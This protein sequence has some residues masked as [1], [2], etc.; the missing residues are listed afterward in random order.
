M[1]AC[2]CVCVFVYIYNVLPLGDAEL[3]QGLGFSV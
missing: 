2:V 1:Y 3:K